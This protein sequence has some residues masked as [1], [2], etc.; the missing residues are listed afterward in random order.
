M[1]SD[2][3]VSPEPLRDHVEAVL[4]RSFSGYMPRFTN[5]THTYFTTYR[6]LTGIPRNLEAQ[7]SVRFTFANRPT[8]GRTRFS[9]QY[10]VRQKPLGSDIWKFEMHSQ[11]QQKAEEFVQRLIAQV[12]ATTSG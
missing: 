8:S 2:V 5:G 3:R 12:K 11:T 7:I 1:K 4:N 6:P 10:L 9:V